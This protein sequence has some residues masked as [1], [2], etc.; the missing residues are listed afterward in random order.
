MAR[1]ILTKDTAPGT[2]AAIGKV[3]TETVW[4]NV[5]GNRFVATGKE[6]VVAHNTD[7]G[8]QTVSVTSVADPY[9]RTGNITTFSIPAGSIAVFGPFNVQ[10]WQQADGYIYLDAAVVAV[11]F[12]ILVLP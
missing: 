7:V 12:A 10:G 1:T 8:A 9:G 5:N 4:D 11:K 6:L 3:L 2:N